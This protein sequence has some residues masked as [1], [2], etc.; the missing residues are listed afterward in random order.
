TQ[1]DEYA[2]LFLD[3]QHYCTICNGLFSNAQAPNFV[4][5]GRNTL[6]HHHLAELKRRACTRIDE[7]GPVLIETSRQI[8][9][10][11]EVAFEEIQASKWLSDL[12][13]QHGFVVERAVGTL[14]TAFRGTL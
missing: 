12:L 1:C 3:M 6:E 9:Q 14:E 2:I 10:H 11:P 4:L 8:L 7:Y 13:E 5:K